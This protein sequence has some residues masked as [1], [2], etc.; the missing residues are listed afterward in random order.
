MDEIQGLL[1]QGRAALEGGNLEQASTLVRRVLDLEGGNKEAR[2][3]SKAIEKAMRAAEK[4]RKKQQTAPE[5]KKEP[6]PKLD[7]AAAGS[8]DETWVMPEKSQKKGSARVLIWAAAGAVLLAAIG[9]AV[10][11]VLLRPKPFDEA[12]LL[13]SAR[14]SLDQKL[15]DNAIELSQ[16]IL[17]TVPGSTNAAAILAEAQKQ[18]KQSSIET[19][20][21]E[22][23]SLRGQKLFEQANATLQRILDIDPA[24]GPAL[25]VR[26]QIEA[27][28]SSTKSEEEQGKNIQEWLNKAKS[29]MAAGK[30][31]EARSEIAKVEKL[32]PDAPELPPLRKQLQTA[33][34]AK[35]AADLAKAKTQKEQQD[36]SQKQARLAE[37]R[38]KATD[39]FGQGKYVDAQ[40]ALDQWL[41][42]E[43]QNSQ[44]LSLRTQIGDAQ[45]SVKA[46]EAA[47]SEKRYEEALNAVAR[48]QK[49]N[50]A[51]PNITAYRK[52]L[53]DTRASARASFSVVRLGEAGT[54]LFD[55]QPVGT[56]GEVDN[57]T[58]PIG[59]HKLTLKN[60]QGKLASIAVDLVDG[61]KADYVYDASVPE[62]RPMAPTDRALLERRKAREEVHSYVVEHNHG[63]FRGR[64][65]GTLTVSGLVVEYRTT[66]TDHN[67]SWPFRTLKL[68][69]RDDRVEFTTADNKT[70]TFKLPDA[71]KAKEV[72]QLWDKLQ[73]LGK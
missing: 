9:T 19:L 23:Q 47:L 38:R 15:Y 14:S 62:L 21:L 61:Q 7:F 55:D 30:L 11:F 34:A 54:L 17:A 10:Y 5:P 16:R 46:F 43:P 72:K 33:V 32:R 6:V 64:C 56:G 59:R 53:E 69:L 57:R 42:D 45:T 52:R 49:A 68:A 41:A 25:D 39:L 4:E 26:S 65:K 37:I 20:M 29:L 40:G 48:L 66:E 1:A 13:A 31:P 18:K 70:Q 36:A 35:A 50:P 67:F 44:A 8:G 12:A 71:A 3:L 27:E 63:T 60:A 2:S 28:V 51:D 58:V 24:Y 22:A 73:Q